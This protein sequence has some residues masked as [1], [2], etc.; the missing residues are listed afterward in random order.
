M[1]RLLLAVCLV[2]VLSW[3]A[4]PKPAPTTLP[5]QSRCRAIFSVT[6]SHDMMKKMAASMTQSMHQL[7][8][9]H[10][11]S[12]R[13]TTRRLRSKDDRENGPDVRQYAL[14]RNMQAMVPAF[15]STSPKATWTTW[16][17]F[18]PRRPAKS[19]CGDARDH[20]RVDARHDA[21]HDQVH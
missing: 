8:H 10:T 4:L 7:A 1:K 21:D 2:S 17:R 19:C 20:G 18:I 16:L 12:T 9:E 6:R 15:K 3:P 5:H 11:R 14:G 13:R